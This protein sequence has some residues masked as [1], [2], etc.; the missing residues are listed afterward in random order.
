MASQTQ[1]PSA[2]QTATSVSSPMAS[3][4]SRM[5]SDLEAF[6]E[7]AGVST[8]TVGGAGTNLVSGGE[9]RSYDSGETGIID[10]LD[11]LQ[12]L[13]L[14]A[15]L[16]RMPVGLVVS[17]PVRDFKVRHLLTMTTGELIESQWGQGEDLPLSS[18]DVQLAWTEFEV[19]DT[20]LA[21]R[22]TRLA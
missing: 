22:V 18:G 14:S 11:D 4:R 20:R 19:V 17:V 15:S 12:S 8:T 5:S 3:A 21:V 10:T 2:T 16:E 1:I 7:S 13:R 9:K 6:Q